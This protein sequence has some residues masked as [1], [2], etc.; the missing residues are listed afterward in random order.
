MEKLSKPLL[1]SGRCIVADYDTAWLERVLK[2]SAREAGTWLPCAHEVAE[3]ILFYLEER[4]PL[5]TL[6]VEF[7]FARIRGLLREIG[8]PLVADHLHTQLP[9][10]DIELDRLA[11]EN[12]LPL[13]FYTRL[14]ERMNVL[15]E[16]GMTTYRFS[17][18]QK[19][20]LV[21][22]CR[23]RACPA[24]RQALKELRLFLANQ[25]AA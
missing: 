10:V 14:Q 2:E 25:A 8:L 16:L 7:L 18:A 13:F 22:G 6:P 23:R 17:G 12:P 24:Q 3:G 5:R 19:C 15:R 9:P 1:Q 21:L 20:S 11:G 4:C